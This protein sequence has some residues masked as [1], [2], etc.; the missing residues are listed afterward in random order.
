MGYCRGKMGGGGC[1]RQ[2]YYHS[3]VLLITIVLSQ[4][5]LTPCAA[6]VPMLSYRRFS[7]TIT[8]IPLGLDGECQIKVLLIITYCAQMSVKSASRFKT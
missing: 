5:S 7:T 6:R 2:Y 8:I 1:L 4:K 3:I